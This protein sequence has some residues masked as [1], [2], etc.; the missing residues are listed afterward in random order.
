MSLPSSVACV[1]T[2]RA[3]RTAERSA[4][5]CSNARMPISQIRN[6]SQC[7]DYGEFVQR[8]RRKAD[9][10][11]GV[12]RTGD[13]GDG[14]RAGHG[15]AWKQC[16]WS[17]WAMTSL[18]AI[19]VGRRCSAGVGLG[20]RRVAHRRARRSLRNGGF[21]LRWWLASAHRRTREWQAVRVLDEAIE[22]GIRQCRVT[23]SE[24]R[25]PGFDRAVG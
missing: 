2:E 22:D 19:V 4:P 8:E 21:G 18:V 17:V 15:A 5:H 9:G 1:I 7:A 3:S 25:M 16:R 24:R 12:K 13:F 10:Q 14:E 20:K 23:A 6:Q 11:F